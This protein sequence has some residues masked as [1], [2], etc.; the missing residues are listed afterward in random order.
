ML[1]NPVAIVRS[2]ERLQMAGSRPATADSTQRISRGVDFPL[3][4]WA[5]L[6]A[7]LC[8][9]PIGFL[10]AVRTVPWLLD[11]ADLTA[12]GAHLNADQRDAAKTVTRHVID[13]GHT[14]VVDD[15]TRPIRV[16]KSLSPT[17]IRSVV[18][19]PV[20]RDHALAPAAV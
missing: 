16:L 6:A 14:V 8:Q 11:G 9:A 18:A 5:K 20:F 3:C 7:R 10:A 13:C 17:I 1:K 15:E 2:A 12:G 4:G 19:T